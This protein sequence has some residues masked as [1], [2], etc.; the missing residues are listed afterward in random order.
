MP[1]WLR[2]FADV[3]VDE[4]W[5][6]RA[7]A[8]LI[9]MNDGIVSAA[10][11]AEGFASA[12]ASSRTVL[13]A[14]VAVILAGSLAA[15]GAR[16]TEEQT[17]SEMNS[18][19]LAAERASIE[20]DPEGEFEELVGLYEAKGLP[21]AL[22]RQVAEALTAH[23]PVAA[24]ADAELRIDSVGSRWESVAAAATA[25]LSFG[26]GALLPLI[27]MYLLPSDQRIELTFLIVLVALVL[28][29]WFAAWLT[30]LP[31]WRLVRRNVVLGSATMLGGLLV[32]RIVD[33]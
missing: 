32:G 33:V 31:P 12:G 28:T 7:R 11:I 29:G 16:Y 24:H 6:A 20:A 23:D 22:A 26:V 19:L 21:S 18:G 8:S 27:A 3:A 30:G 15:A 1:G 25:G 10:G 5:R 2:G 17:E 13:F 9:E 14:G 4:G